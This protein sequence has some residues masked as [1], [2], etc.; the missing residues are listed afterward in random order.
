MEIDRFNAQ[1]VWTKS[2]GSEASD[3]AKY[4]LDKILIRNYLDR[5]KNENKFE[6]GLIPKIEED[7]EKVKYES[8]E[9]KQILKTN[10]YILQ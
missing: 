10:I 1:E 4:L 3:D 2:D 6:K 8:E 7:I 5:G 9:T